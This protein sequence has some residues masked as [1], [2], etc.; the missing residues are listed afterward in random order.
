MRIDQIDENLSVKSK[1]EIKGLK[2]R[3]VLD[4]PFDIYGLY[5]TKKTGE[6]IRLP[7][8]AAKEISPEVCHLGKHT[9]GGRIRFRTNSPYVAVKIQIQWQSPMPHMP[10][11]GSNG[12]DLYVY[13]NGRDVYQGTFIPPIE[14]TD[15][16]ESVVFL[17]EKKMHDVTIHLP[18]YCGVKTLYIGLD[19]NAE[20]EKGR[21][22]RQVKPILYYGSSI[23][24]GG[25]VSRPGNNYP[26]AIA[27]ETNVDFVCLGFSGGAKGEHRMAEYLAEIDA[28]IFV[29][30][31][32]HNAPTVEH[33]KD[34]HSYIYECY[35]KYHP[36]TPIVFVSR[37]NFSPNN[38]M[39]VKRRDVVYQTYHTA[40]EHG[41]NKVYFIDGFQL[42]A[43]NRRWDCTVD[44][45]HPNDLGAFRMAEVIGEVVKQYLGIF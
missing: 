32:D 31:Y 14:M 44:G 27:R 6:Y 34:T 9:S 33:L 17:P 5:Q 20:I 19:E 16:Y 30:D 42:F 22:Y 23:T 11:T 15:S 26:A 43:G 28:S 24:Q 18:L 39:D 21:P 12:L 41:D 29:C 37:P 40:L 3:N 4:S 10:R 1:L 7:M 25:C 8:D 38:T 45:V 36:K 35:R 2:Y 13:E